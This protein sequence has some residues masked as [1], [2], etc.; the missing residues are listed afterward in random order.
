MDKAT[1]RRAGQSMSLRSLVGS[2]CTRLRWLIARSKATLTAFLMLEF[3]P[4][5]IFSLSMVSSMPRGTILDLGSHC[6]FKREER[7]AVRTVPMATCGGFTDHLAA[8]SP[9]AGRDAQRTPG[10]PGLA[11]VASPDQPSGLRAGGMAR[12]SCQPWEGLGAQGRCE[13]RVITTCPPRHLPR[14]HRILEAGRRQA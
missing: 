2:P 6:L 5:I 9:Q 7:G 4:S 3:R 1:G 12:P 10:A 11:P 14:S 13:N 8:Q